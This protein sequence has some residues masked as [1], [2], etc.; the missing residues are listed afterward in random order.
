MSTLGVCLVLTPWEQVFCS[1][2]RSS[3]V[4]M[5][6]KI[7]HCQIQRPL[8]KQEIQ[9]RIHSNW[10]SIKNKYFLQY[11]S[12]V[13]SPVLLNDRQFLEIF[14]KPNWCSLW[15][16]YMETC[17]VCDCNEHWSQFSIMVLTAQNRKGTVESQ[18]QY[19]LTLKCSRAHGC[20]LPLH[21]SIIL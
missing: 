4:S 18:R 2:N 13:T 19:T 17:T 20:S 21:R 16:V 12:F 11:V 9:Y 1:Y 5:Q 14:L 6:K 7:M 10:S 8:S 3:R 15:A